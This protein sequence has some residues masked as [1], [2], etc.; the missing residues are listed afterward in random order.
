MLHLVT[1]TGGTFAIAFYG[2]DYNTTYVVP[3]DE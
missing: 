1:R 2:N 3:T